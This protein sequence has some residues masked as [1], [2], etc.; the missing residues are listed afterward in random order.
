MHGSAKRNNSPLDFALSIRYTNKKR[1]EAGYTMANIEIERKFLIVLP[2]M[3]YLMSREGLTK[4]EIT[5]TYLV[6]RN[7]D[8]ERRIRKIKDG[9]KTSYIYTE[10]QS[11]SKLSRHEDEHEISENE[12]NEKY[13]RESHS[14]LTKT[15]YS[16]PYDGHVIEIDVYPHDIGGDELDGYAVL[17][18][19]L[20]SEHEEFCLP[21]EISVVRELTGTREFSNKTLAKR[22]K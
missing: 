17:E 12:Y 20:Q 1:M 6:R 11:L 7:E 2:S 16:F 18:V 19:E 9:E 15:R 8:T 4:L 3:E 5:Q 10:K 21:A 13:I 14:R 22:V